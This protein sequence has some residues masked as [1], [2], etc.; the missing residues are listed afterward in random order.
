MT[1]QIP[2]QLANT[3]ADMLINLVANLLEL[4][5]QEAINTIFDGIFEDEVC[6][7]ARFYAEICECLRCCFIEYFRFAESE[8]KWEVFA[9]EYKCKLTYGGQVVDLAKLN[10]EEISFLI[11]E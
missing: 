3:N 5:K 9:D 2:T 7:P 10:I 11:G 8:W 6:T 1:K 4:D